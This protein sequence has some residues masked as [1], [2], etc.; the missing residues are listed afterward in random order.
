[1]YRTDKLLRMQKSRGKRRPGNRSRTGEDRKRDIGMLLGSSSSMLNAVRVFVAVTF[2]GSGVGCVGSRVRP[3]PNVRPVTMTVTATGY[4]PCGRCCNWRRN[5]WGRPVIASGPDKGKPKRV[6]Y[7]ATGTRARKGTIAADPSVFP[8]GTV[9]FVPG[10]GYGRVEDTGSA[11]QGR[12]IDLF[13]P[14]HSQAAAWGRRVL[15]VKVWPPQ[16]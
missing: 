12:H 10:Y 15:R 1:M 13:F 8:Y 2:L 9:F 14:R 11:L 3:P 4:C 5:I 16:K 6:G 7:T